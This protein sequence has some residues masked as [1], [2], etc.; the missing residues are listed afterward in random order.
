MANKLIMPVKTFHVGSNNPNND[1]ELNIFNH[2]HQLLVKLH[3]F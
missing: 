2:P 3:L 1:K